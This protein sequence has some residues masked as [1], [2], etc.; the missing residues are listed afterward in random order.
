MILYCSV[1]YQVLSIAWDEM[2]YCWV[3]YEDHSIVL[4]MMLYS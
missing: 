4:C 2:L 1:V 3:E